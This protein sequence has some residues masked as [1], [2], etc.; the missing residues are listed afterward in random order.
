MT[1]AARDREEAEAVL[2]F[3]G[4]TAAHRPLC[5][6]MHTLPQP[7]CDSFKGVVELVCT[8]VGSRLTPHWLFSYTCSWLHYQGM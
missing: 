6:E 3:A 2:M 4:R 7:L 1:G 8:E 5:Q